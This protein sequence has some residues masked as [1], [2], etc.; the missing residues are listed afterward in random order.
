M[1]RNPATNAVCGRSYSSSGA[2][3]CSIVPPVHDRDR[4]GHRHGL[5]LVVRHVD[6]RDAE[7]VL[8]P[9]EEE[10]HLLA[11]LEIERTERLVQQQH[12]RPA[13][14]CPG[15]RD[16]LLLASG[17]LPRLTVPESRQLDELAACLRTRP[18]IWLFG[19]RCRSRP[20][21][22]FSEIER[23]G[24]SAYDWKTVLTSRL[25]GG[26]PTTSRSPRKMPPCSAPR[27]RRSCAASSSC[28]SRTGRAARRTGRA[29]LPA[30]A[31]PRPRHR[32]NA[33]RHLPDGRRRRAQSRDPHSPLVDLLAE[34]EVE[35]ALGGRLRRQARGCGSSARAGADGPHRRAR[36]ARRTGRR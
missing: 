24:K 2:P 3:S 26:C 33:S 36:R 11:K 30:R 34:L 32:R 35:E 22:M 29:P 6:E 31:R 16:A 18:L 10:L 7:L 12:S 14:E 13:H 5:L 19:T 4:V 27:S 17:E 21:A 20:K 8:N 23:C 25:Y 28:R 1:P 15:Q 9:L